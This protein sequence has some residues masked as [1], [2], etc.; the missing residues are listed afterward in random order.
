MRPK[1]K[2]LVK[3]ISE[4]RIKILLEE[5]KKIFEKNPERARRYCQL[6]FLI[7]KKNK[8]RLTKVQKLSF[9]RKCFAF[10]RP[11]KTAS[12]LFDKK[13]KRVIY[14]CGKCG[15]ERKIGYAKH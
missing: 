8:V 13:N 6:A 14:K 3:K 1:E 15:Y 2:N 9:C 12:V 5:A 11:G 10:W 7:V 4:E